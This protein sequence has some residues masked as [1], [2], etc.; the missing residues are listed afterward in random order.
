M[1][2]HQHIAVSEEQLHSIHLRLFDQQVVVRSDS[3][4]YIEL[5]DQL[6]TRFQTDPPTE[7]AEPTLSFVVLTGT[8]RAGGRPVLLVNNELQ[9]LGKSNVPQGHIY[10]N[11]LNTIV[12]RVRSH[13]LIHA[14]VVTW[15]NQGV[16]LA[17][18]SCHGKTTLSLALLRRGF[19]FLSD[20]MAALDRT[21]GQVHPF[22]RSLRVRPG[23]FE[24]TG[25]S[26]AARDASTWLDKLIVDIDD[27]KP[28]SIGTNAPVRYVVIL[29]RPGEADAESNDDHHLEVYVDRVDRK[30]VADAHR[31][32]DID[33][34]HVDASSSYPRLVIGT[35]D[36]VSA[37]TRLQQLCR[38]H[39]I[40]IL[41]VVK[42]TIT[43]P[44]FAGPVQLDRIQLSEA[45]LELLRHF[46][47]GHQSALLHEEHNGSSV[48]LFRE[49]TTII[50]S[51]ECYR[52]TVGPLEE[53]V[54]CVCRVVRSGDV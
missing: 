51:A 21:D 33:S 14:G 32:R 23:T 43:H 52:L 44:S 30:I 9:P 11:I 7:P 22:P 4:T 13:I 28:G 1:F 53:M 48:R 35:S 20:E 54:D 5:F 24:Q 6:Y 38:Q 45:T 46:L 25:F 10:E 49:L 17:A 39:N 42:R 40:L 8:G 12:A 50:R 27:I 16:V 36:R 26:A 34:L 15:Q 29:H 41:N 19:K 2:A 31:I 37:L 47:G 18:D 3:R